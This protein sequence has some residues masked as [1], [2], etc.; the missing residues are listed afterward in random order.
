MNFLE[1]TVQYLRDAGATGV[2]RKA[3][4]EDTPCRASNGPSRPLDPVQR[5]DFAN[6]PAGPFTA[7]KDVVASKRARLIPASPGTQ[8]AQSPGPGFSP[9]PGRNLLRSRYHRPSARQLFAAADT[10]SQKR[11]GPWSLQ[12]DL[13]PGRG[14]DSVCPA[15]P[16]PRVIPFWETGRQE[17]DLLKRGVELYQRVERMTRHVQS[18][19]FTIDLTGEDEAGPSPP[20]AGKPGYAQRLH[21]GVDPW[22]EPDAAASSSG[23]TLS[24]PHATGHALLAPLRQW[25]SEAGDD[26]PQPA[27]GRKHHAP[28]SDEA[29][30]EPEQRPSASSRLAKEAA[31]AGQAL[32][33]KA[34]SIL[35]AKEKPSWQDLRSEMLRIK[36]ELDRL[37][38]ERL[39]RLQPKPST[40]VR[41]SISL[42]P[43][44]KA[45]YKALVQGGAASDKLVEHTGSNITLTRHDVATLGP[46]A[47]LN[48]EVINLTMTLLQERD[49]S[50]RKA[51]KSWPKTHFFST[52]FCN[53]LYK[54]GGYSYAQ[55]RRWTT[56]KRLAAAGQA[57]PCLL[58]CDRIVVPVH[59]GMHWVCAVVDLRNQELRYLDA[60]KG[61]D[62]GCLEALAKW[63]RDEF[64]DKRKEERADV[65]KWPRKFPKTVPQQYNGYDCGMFLLQFADFEGRGEAMTFTQADMEAY[66]I[67]TVLDLMDLCIA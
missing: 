21:R 57:S 56:P 19:Q 52:F 50:A 66:R 51:Q 30:D 34:D 35:E 26:E 67:K 45:K 61:E 11:R 7:S 24:A 17:R 40:S 54:D 59:Q 20:A 39:K 3:F 25:L 32:L 33:E 16:P 49:T 58:D 18:P 13:K 28:R 41:P 46:G 42:P 31:E 48:D 43:G 27:A 63:L 10:P 22:G 1:K 2:K 36:E 65:L 37:E 12:Q 62:E 38:Q 47:W 23:A 29:L 55:V 14:P 4:A 6:E 44:A 15:E 9:F 60:L 64:K 5:L 53:K 8:R